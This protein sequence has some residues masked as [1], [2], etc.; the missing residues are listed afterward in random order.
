MPLFDVLDAAEADANIRNSKANYI[1]ELLLNLYAVVVC[2]GAEMDTYHPFVFCSCSDVHRLV[3][4]YFE[5]RF[6]TFFV[7][8]PTYPLY[9]DFIKLHF[10]SLITE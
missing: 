9:S 3:P 7:V 5:E 10:Y 1:Q 4:M 2:L 8:S 6:V